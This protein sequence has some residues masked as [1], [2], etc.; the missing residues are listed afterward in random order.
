VTDH[1]RSIAASFVPSRVTPRESRH[2]AVVVRM[3]SAGAILHVGA[4]TEVEIG[5][6]R[7]APHLLPLPAGAVVE[8]TLLGTLPRVTGRLA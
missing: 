5:P 7:V 3:E 6:V 1:R 4:D 8:L 2:N